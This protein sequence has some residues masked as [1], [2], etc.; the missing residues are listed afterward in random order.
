MDSQQPYRYS[1]CIYFRLSDR[2]PDTRRR[3]IDLTWKLLAT[4]HIGM[5]NCT[6]GFRDVLMQRPVNDQMF[7]ISVDM[8][9]DSLESYDAYRVNKHHEEWITLAGSMSI[10]RVVFDSYLLQRPQAGEFS[11]GR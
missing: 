10:D 3:F 11:D 9:F 5:L 4:G 7:D 1:H 6:I 2:T 8:T